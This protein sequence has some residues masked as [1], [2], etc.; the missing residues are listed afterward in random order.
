MNWIDSHNQVDKGGAVG[1]HRINCLLSVDDLVLLSS[2]EQ[3]LQQ[4]LDQFSAACS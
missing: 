4:A 3:E 2:C 1:S